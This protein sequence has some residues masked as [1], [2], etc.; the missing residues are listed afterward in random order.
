MD[1]DATFLQAPLIHPLHDAPK[2]I[3]LISKILPP[4]SMEIPHYIGFGGLTTMEKITHR[5]TKK[6]SPR[7]LGR[8]YLSRILGR[9][10]LSRILRRKYLSRSTKLGFWFE[11]ISQPS[12][13]FSTSP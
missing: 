7:F 4:F 5:S 10:Y 6:G 3:S 1:D 9:K 13:R 8:K 11:K 12:M 2:I